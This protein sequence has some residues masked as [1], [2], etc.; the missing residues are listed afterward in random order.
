VRTRDLLRHRAALSCDP[1][2]AED[3]GDG[4]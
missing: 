2:R 4:S 3:G 1:I